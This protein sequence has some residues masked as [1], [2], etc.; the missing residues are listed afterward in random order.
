MKYEVVLTDRAEHELRAA[1]DWIALSAPETASKWFN[2]FAAAL[3]RIGD[4]PYRCAVA[5]ESKRFPYE[6]RQM[7]FGRRRTYRAIYTIRER[8]AVV[9]RIRHSAQQELGLDDL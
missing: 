6:V 2:R 1:A 3:I 9:L 8:T 4:N 7:T 5:S